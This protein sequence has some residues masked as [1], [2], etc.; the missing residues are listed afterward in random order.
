VKVA[1]TAPLQRKL[2]PVSLSLGYSGQVLSTR[3]YD[4]LDTDDHLAMFRLAVG[5]S[6]PLTQGILELGLSWSTGSTSAYAHQTVAADLWLTGV[7]LG[8]TWRY[9][10][11]KHLEPY[12]HLGAGWDWATLQLMQG[13]L[14][15]TTSNFQAT[16]LLGAQVPVKLGPADSRAPWLLLDF[17][18]GYAFRPDYGF[19]AM[20]PP[21]PLPG[22]EDPIAQGSVNLG[23]IA[24]S[25]IQYRILLTF[26]L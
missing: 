22:A 10:L 11:W 17:G 15:Q 18:L 24:L 2:P 21:R 3:G 13:K 26:R 5:Y 7:E 14:L 20:G 16:L 4:L 19:R 9:P 6:L 8:A 23:R 12:A 1:E 25:G